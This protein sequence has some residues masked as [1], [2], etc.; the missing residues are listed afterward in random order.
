MSC[1]WK[2]DINSTIVKSLHPTALDEDLNTNAKYARMLIPDY[3]SHNQLPLLISQRIKTKSRSANGN[4]L[5][6]IA[7][8]K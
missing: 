8:K 2:K 5:Q 7:F 3:L 6:S 4:L 1:Q